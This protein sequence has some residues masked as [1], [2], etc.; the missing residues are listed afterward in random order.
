L[1]LLGV[2]LVGDPSGEPVKAVAD[3]PLGL[4]DGDQVEAAVNAARSSR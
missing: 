3:Q 4:P 2:E 1:D